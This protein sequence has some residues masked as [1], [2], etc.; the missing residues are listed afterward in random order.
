MLQRPRRSRA[1]VAVP[2]IVRPTFRGPQP[3]AGW[4]DEG[5]AAD[6]LPQAARQLA[7]RAPAPGAGTDVA[8]SPSSRGGDDGALVDGR[9]DDPET[10]PLLA[11]RAV[12]RARAGANERAPSDM[13]EGRRSSPVAAYAAA[14]LLQRSA[15]Q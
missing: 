5:R 15:Q 14:H 4:L 2:S 12:A 6:S 3:L 13:T 11:G 1:T 8:L 7:R 9:T 10:L